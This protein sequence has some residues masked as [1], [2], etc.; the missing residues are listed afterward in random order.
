VSETTVTALGVPQPSLH[1]VYS[2][3]AGFGVGMFLRLRGSLR[4]LAVLPLLLVSADHA[5][6]NYE[7]RAGVG[8]VVGDALAAPFIAAQP[9][10]GVWPL[11]A[12]GCGVA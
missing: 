3:L 5:A 2:A 12:R 7:G 11:V 10:L 6:S 8:S 4:M 9:W 1:V